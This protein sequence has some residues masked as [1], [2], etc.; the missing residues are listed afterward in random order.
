[1]KCQMVVLVLTFIVDHDPE[2]II[3]SAYGKEY[4]LKNIVY[5]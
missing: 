1:M 2:L 5:H 4:P 3:A